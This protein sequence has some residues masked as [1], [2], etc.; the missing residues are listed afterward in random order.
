LLLYLAGI[1]DLNGQ[2]VNADM[3]YLNVF[4]KHK[5]AKSNNIYNEIRKSANESLLLMMLY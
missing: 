2:L 5:N 4:A 1:T 3:H